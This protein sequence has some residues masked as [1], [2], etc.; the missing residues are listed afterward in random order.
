MELENSQNNAL[1]KLPMLKLGEYEMWEIRIKQYFQIQDYALWE[2]IENGNSWVPIPVT[3]PES[4]P[5]TALKMTVPS[6]TEEKICK[7]NDVKARSLLLMALPNEH[8]L[9]FNQMDHHGWEVVMLDMINQS[10]NVSTRHKNGNFAE[11]LEHQEVKRHRKLE[12]RRVI[13]GSKGLKMLHEK[14]YWVSDDKDEDEEVVDAYPKVFCDKQEGLTTSYFMKVEFLVNLQVLKILGPVLDN[15]FNVVNKLIWTSVKHLERFGMDTWDTYTVEAMDWLQ[16]QQRKKG[17]FISQDKYVHEI[18]RKF[19]YTYV[20]SASTP[21]DLEKPLVK[22]ADADDVDEHLYRSMIGSLMYLTASRPDII[23]L[24]GKPS[25]GLWYSKNS[26]LELI[27]YTD[28]DYAGATLDR[29]STT[30]GCQ[31]LGNRLIFWQCKKQTVVATSITEAEYVATASCCGQLIQMA[32]IDTQLNVADLL[33]KGFDAGRFQYL[34]SSIGMLNPQG[35]NLLSVEALT[36]G[37]GDVKINATIDGYSLFITKGSLRR[38]LKLDDQD[39]ITSIPTTEIFEQLALMGYHTNSDNP[40]KTAWEQFSSNIAAAII[41]LATNRKFNFSRM[42]FEHMVSNIS[43][44]YKFLMYPRFIQLCLDM[45]RHKLQQHTRLYSVPSLTMKVFSNM[46]RSTKGFSGQ[47]VALF[48]TMLDDTKPSPSPSR[49]TSSPSPTPSPSPDPTPTQPLPTQPLPTQPSSSQHSP[50]QLSPIQPS[51][52]QPRTEYH[53]PTPHDSPLHAVHSY[54]SDEGSLKLQELM[55]LVTT[56]SDRIGSLQIK[57]GKRAGDKLRVVLKDD[58]YCR[59]KLSTARG[60][61]N[62]HEE[63]LRKAPR[64]LRK[65][66]LDRGRTQIAQARRNMIKYLK[67]QGNY[68]ISNFKEHGSEQQKSLE[69]EKSPEKIV[70][71]EVETQEE[72]KEFPIVDWKTYVLTETFMYYQVFRGDGS[73]KNYKI[74]TEMLRDFDRHDV[75]E[76]YRL[77]KERYR[78]SRPEGYDLMLWGDLHTMFEPNADDELWKNQH[79]Y[80]VLSWSLYNFCGIHMLLME[81]GMAIHMLIEKKI[82]FKPRDDFQDVEEEIRG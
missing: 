37:N 36:D 63:V 53:L 47:E 18:L 82:S 23:Y 20:K 14:E 78:A 68:K 38:H 16:V 59:G 40:K 19:N 61:V 42:I 7:K 4:G 48:P 13:I 24:K 27:A 44:P 71:E 46:K 11:Y 26:P 73:S 9:T 49:I 6:T 80:N 50:T 8:Q 77:V 33:T 25:L 34:V 5:S 54:G 72:K 51:P 31:F 55:H 74:F 32:K 52:T 45:Q 17:I 12:S 22:D 81:N 15:V 56:L 57:I 30:R 67:N 10:W 66:H 70:E 64:Q 39:G 58:V 76:L 29:K 28:S 65:S 75:E 2:V 1:A 41:Y 69:K 3:T 21:T 62:I 43:S 35:P 79:Q 60:T